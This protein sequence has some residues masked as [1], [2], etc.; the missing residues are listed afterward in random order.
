MILS[1]NDSVYKDI[2]L[3]KKILFICE[4]DKDHHPLMSL[5]S[6]LYVFAK[7]NRRP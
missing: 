1:P 4:R 3:I 2:I 5:L 6:R 7:K